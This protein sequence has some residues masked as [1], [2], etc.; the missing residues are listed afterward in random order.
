M[1]PFLAF[2]VWAGLFYI[3][4]VVVTKD[5]GLSIWTVI[6]WLI[7]VMAGRL[8]VTFLASSIG[9]SIIPSLIAGSAAALGVLI[10]ILW[11]QG[12]SREQIVK[13]GVLVGVL[14]IAN[15]ILRIIR[16]A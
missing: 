8:L 3:I 12:Y 16:Q 5:R 10:F 7:A 9:L 6:F 1:I 14:Q 15:T 11:H 2:I 13:I 4:V